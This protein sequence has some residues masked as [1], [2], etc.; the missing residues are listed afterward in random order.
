MESK[1]SRRLTQAIAPE[2]CEHIYLPRLL[3]EFESGF[4][5]LNEINQA[6]LLMLHANGLL[7]DAA[8]RT[9]ARALLQMEEEGPKAVQ[10]DPAREDAFFNYEARLMEVAGADAGGSLHMA[11]SRNDIAATLDRLRARDATLLLLD[12]L[13]VAR[14]T[15]L[16]K[17]GE[18]T[19]TVMPGYTHL[20]AAQPIT[21]GYYLAAVA[22][23][24]GRDINRLTHALEAL[25]TCPLGA[26]ALAG[27]S[28]PIDRLSTARWLGFSRYVDNALDAV[29]SRDFAWEIQAALTIGALTWGR[30]AQ[31]YYV[32]ATPEFGLIDFPDSIAATSSI[33]PQKKNPVVLEHLKGKGGHVLGLL[34]A[35][36][37]AV[38]GTHFTHTVDGNRESMRS[39]WESAEESL[40]CVKLLRLILENATPLRENM[41]ARANRDFSAATDLADALVRDAGVS[42][43]QAHHI[44]GAVVRDAL[45][46]KLIASEITSDMVD[47]AAKQYTGRP[48]ALNAS[49]VAR[50]LDPEIAVKARVSAGSPSPSKVLQNLS[51]QLQSLARSRAVVAEE[52]K[53]IN[54]SRVA[55]KHAVHS[56]LQGSR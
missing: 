36:L 52:Q 22:E 38:K 28:F 27:T 35:S 12:A 13:L 14:A 16:D 26:A 29:A 50:C 15:A 51:D 56:L 42:F 9:L 54:D 8:A 11:R 37:S 1:V 34:T 5:Y 24:L 48:T 31:D 18:H 3:R 43:R 19:A 45:D 46:R 6:H 30:V 10:L 4:P 2:V 21:Y 39:F 41:R 17:A 32:W 40:R 44:V 47:A 7:P 55:L 49:T 20:Q 33:M 23:V 25:D 53:R